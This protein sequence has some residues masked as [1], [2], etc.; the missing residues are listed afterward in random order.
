MKL[1]KYMIIAAPV[2][3]LLLMTIAAPD[4]KAWDGGYSHYGSWGGGCGYGCGYHHNWGGCEGCGDNGGPGIGNLLSGLGQWTGIGIGEQQNYGN[5]GGGCGNGCG[6]GGGYYDTGYQAGQTEAQSDYQSNLAYTPHTSY[7]CHGPEW[8]QG[9]RSGY[10]ATWTSIHQDQ[11]QTTSQGIDKRI[12]V[13]DS[14]GAHVSISN[15]QGST[16]N[17]G[18]DGGLGP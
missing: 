6:N 17:Q 12:N 15:N 18:Q 3:L 5:D 13:I 16:S 7:C 2:V 14:P 4:V 11:Q 10:D 8:N 9:F 1:I